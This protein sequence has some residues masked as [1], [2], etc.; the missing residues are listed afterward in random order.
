[1]YKKGAAIAAGS[2]MAL[3]AATPAFADAE[4]GALAKHSPGVLSGNVLQVPLDLQLNVC[5]NSDSVT[6]L[7]NPSFGNICANH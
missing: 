4:A 5:G 7:L 3:G 2:L 1:M 6:G